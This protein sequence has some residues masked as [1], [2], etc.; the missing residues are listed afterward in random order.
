L[1]TSGSTG[2]PKGVQ[3]SHKSAVN[4]LVFM[5]RQPG[6]GP[7][8]TVFSVTSVSFDM[9]VVDIYLPLIVGA[10]LVFGTREVARD[11]YALRAALKR[12]GATL[13]Q[14]TPATWQLLITTTDDNLGPIKLLS[15]GDVLT[16][17]V[18]SKLME[19]GGS[20]WNLYG[21]TETAVYTCFYHAT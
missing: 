6:L 19:R 4:T 5:E 3:I 16:C 2:V 1:Y 15:A 13:F 21:T 9:F 7:T 17:E 18:T 20:V 12:S 14:G 8:D 11:G 10:K